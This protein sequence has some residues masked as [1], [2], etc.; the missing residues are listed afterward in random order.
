MEP[1]QIITDKEQLN[2]IIKKLVKQFIK[3]KQTEFK[4]TSDYPDID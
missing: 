4:L 3:P 1:T 2:R